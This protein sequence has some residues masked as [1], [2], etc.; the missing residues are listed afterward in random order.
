VIATN[1]SST[2]NKDTILEVGQKEE[3]HAGK[4]QQQPI[5]LALPVSEK[6]KLAGNQQLRVQQISPQDN[7]TTCHVFDDSSSINSVLV[8]LLNLF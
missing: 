4:K 8:L 7:N 5:L 1:N 6:Y 3:E 2:T